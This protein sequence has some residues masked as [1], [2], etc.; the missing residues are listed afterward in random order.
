MCIDTATVMLGIAEG[1]ASVFNILGS[2]TQQVAAADQTK[3]KAV[4]L[5]QSEQK[6][7][8][9]IASRSSQ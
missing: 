5:A 9:V 1:R 4:H 8:A 6:S 2:T 3:E 7:E